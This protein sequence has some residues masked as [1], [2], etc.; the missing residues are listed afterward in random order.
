[1][2]TA[3]AILVL[4]CLFG[5]VGRR[6]FTHLERAQAQFGVVATRLDVLRHDLAII[7]A[8]QAALRDGFHTLTHAVREAGMRISSFTLPEPQIVKVEVPVPGKQVF[9]APRTVTSPQVHLVLMD[10]DERDVITTRKIVAHQRAPRV[11]YQGKW[12]AAVSG[13]NSDGFFI[14]RAE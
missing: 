11:E 14:Y 2:L 3:F 12:Y 8:E 10:K 13:S 6:V 4:A 1:M 7:R 5:F 9:T